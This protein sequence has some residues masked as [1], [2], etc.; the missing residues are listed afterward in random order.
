MDWERELF[1]LVFYKIK[2]GG[3]TVGV[4]VDS[5]ETAFMNSAGRSQFFAKPVS[6]HL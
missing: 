6:N 1:F 2:G 4:G 5:I 3:A